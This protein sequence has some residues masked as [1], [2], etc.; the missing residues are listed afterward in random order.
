M[1]HFETVFQRVVEKWPQFLVMIVGLVLVN[2]LVI[3]FKHG[4]VLRRRDDPSPSAQDDAARRAKNNRI[5][6]VG[7][8]LL[9]LIFWCIGFAEY[10]R[11]G[12]INVPDVGVLCGNGGLTGL[13]GSGL[14][15]VVSSS[16][17]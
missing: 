8:A 10:S 1:S 14:L 3:W 7:M 6:L 12:C 5:I 15:L 9:G 16:L 2:I 11:S 13:V 4:R 17:C